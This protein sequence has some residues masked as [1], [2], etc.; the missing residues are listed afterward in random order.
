[1]A[2]LNYSNYLEAIVNGFVAALPEDD[3]KTSISTQLSVSENEFVEQA[4]RS[5]KDDEKKIDL[6]TFSENS[7]KSNRD[8]ESAIEQ[9]TKCEETAKITRTEYQRIKEDI[10]ELCVSVLLSNPK[11]M[12]FWWKT[13]FSA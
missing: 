12:L 2:Q 8:E 10:Q 4:I 13:S 6:P 5:G 9:T 11:F 7:I 3:Q 1:M